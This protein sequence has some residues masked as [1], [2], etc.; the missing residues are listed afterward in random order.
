MA[1]LVWGLL[2]IGRGVFLL[3]A[4]GVWELG[5][6]PLAC[7]DLSGSAR[8]RRAKPRQ[9]RSRRRRGPKASLYEDLFADRPSPAEIEGARIVRPRLPSSRRMRQLL[10]CVD[11]DGA[12]P[13]T[14]VLD[15]RG[16][17]V[18]RLGPSGRARRPG[19][20]RVLRSGE[21]GFPAG[22]DPIRGVPSR[23]RPKA[24]MLVSGGVGTPDQYA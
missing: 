17:D 15:R 22:P 7:F 14:H 2:S 24:C 8:C 21:V 9:G 19:L 16:G 23:L 11:S 10:V 13:R 20:G 1:G 18:R 6:G 12:G 4:A 5:R 3:L